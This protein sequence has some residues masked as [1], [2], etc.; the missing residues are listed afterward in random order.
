M[1]KIISISFALI[2]GLIANAQ[3]DSVYSFSIDEAINFAYDNNINVEN[4]LLDIKKAKWKVW[5]TTAIGLPQV[6]GS[7]QYQ[8]FPDIPTQLMPN[9]MLPAIIGVNTQYFGLIPVQPIPEEGEKFAVQFG[10]EHNADWGVS[11]SQIIF[12]GEY[13]VGLQASRTYKLISEQSYDKAKIELKS[14]VEQAYYLALIAKQ[15]L[16]IMKQNYSNIQ[17]LLDDTQK[18]VDAGVTEQTQADQIKILE[19]NLKNQISSLE[20]Q[21]QLAMLML[22]LQLGL[23]PQDSVVLSSSLIDVTDNL[24]LQLIGQSFDVNNNIDYQMMNTQVQLKSLDLRRSQSTTLP[25]V[26]GFYSYSEQAMRDEFNFFDDEYDWF[27]T[28]VVGVKMEIPI[29]SSGQRTAVIQQKKIELYQTVNQQDLLDQQLNM[30]YIQYKSDFL[31]AYD[32]LIS[33][34]QNLNLS[35]KI[36]NDTQTKYKQGAASSMDL[37]QMQNQYLQAEAAYYQTLMQVLNAKIALEKLL[38]Q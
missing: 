8:N 23:L 5:E 38:N 20:R 11:V 3:T 37:T 14:T 27:P 32:N 6:S 16:N 19:L 2:I 24:N 7:M 12:S 34:E 29:F 26:V 22:N 33:Q 21:E 13:I 28:S 4:S 30:Q 25:T 10:S 35:L 9:F 36:Y 17:K 1:K 31:N 18:M 15:S